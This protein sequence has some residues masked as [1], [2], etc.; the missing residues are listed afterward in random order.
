MM[1]NTVEYLTS[2]DSWDSFLN[3]VT[4]S[5]KS[6]RALFVW[7]G[8]LDSE[9]LNARE[10]SLVEKYLG[11]TCD[12]TNEFKGLA[13]FHGN[14][15]NYY[16]SVAFLVFFWKQTKIVGRETNTVLYIDSDAWFSDEAFAKIDSLGPEDYFQLSPHASLFGNQNKVGGKKIVMN[17][18]LLG[19]RN[20]TW[21]HNWSALWWFTR[22]GRRDQ[23]G[24][25]LT[26]FADWSASTERKLANSKEDE[27]KY[28]F[29]YDPAIFT[30]YREARKFALGQLRRNVKGIQQTYFDDPTYTLPH[31]LYDG[32]N[33]S[34][35]SLVMAPLEL[36][37]VMILP[38][39]AFHYDPDVPWASTAGMNG[40]RPPK[41]DLIALR[42]DFDER[43]PSLVCHTKVGLTEASGH[44][45]GDKICTMGKCQPWV[46][47]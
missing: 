18:G 30:S 34:N 38:T 21:V 11:A 31:T 14:T 28:H 16:K 7:I 32:G 20:T 29:G 42:S 12:T 39:G 27:T 6:G 43:R 10:T 8:D 1:V 26:L 46:L 24:L 9:I 22:C 47:G 45:S 17:G 25:W 36:P 35:S 3:K 15:M 23:R 4:Y 41:I 37:N 40:W 44:C 33:F 2:E 19:M 13:E 5:E